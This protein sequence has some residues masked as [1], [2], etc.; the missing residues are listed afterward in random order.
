[1][2]FRIPPPR[3]VARTGAPV[4]VSVPYLGSVSGLREWTDEGIMDASERWY[5]KRW[6]SEREG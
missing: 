4:S 3:H 1:M 2:R 6:E 5:Q